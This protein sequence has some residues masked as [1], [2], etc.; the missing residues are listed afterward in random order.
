MADNL[1]ASTAGKMVI[2]KN[3]SDHRTQLIQTWIYKFY[4][5]C[6]LERSTA[7]LNC[8]RKEILETGQKPYPI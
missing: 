5:I 7:N 6:I 4:D 2:L 8:A 1:A 3:W